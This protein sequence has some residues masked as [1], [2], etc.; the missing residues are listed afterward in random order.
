M[1]T[2]LE[3]ANQLDYLMGAGTD[4][5]S[6]KEENS[7]GVN[8][9]HA[10]SIISTFQMEEEDGTTHDMLLIRNPWGE[11]DYSWHWSRKDQRW[12]DDLVR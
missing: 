11:T 2:L 10:F 1:F 3:N 12:T 9:A 4:G 6:D 7:C 5:T 8:M